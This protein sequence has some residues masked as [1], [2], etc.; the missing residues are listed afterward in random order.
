MDIEINKTFL[1]TEDTNLLAPNLESTSFT[2]ID[3]LH[4]L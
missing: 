4:S 3:I 2:K 1:A